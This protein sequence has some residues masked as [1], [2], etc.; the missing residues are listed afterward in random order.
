MSRPHWDRLALALSLAAV[1]A[2]GLVTWGIFDG[3][4]HLEDEF[5]NLW[6]A[7]VMADGRLRLPS[8]PEAPSFLVPFVVD[9]EG[10]RFGKYPPGWPAA[11]S[12]GARAGAAWLVNPLLA[13][14][15]VWLTYRLASRFLSGGASLLAAGL[16]ASSPIFLIQ[17]GAIMSHNLSLALALIFCLAWLD[18]FVPPLSAVPEWVLA[19]VAG[20]SLGLLAL[21]RP[22]TAVGVGL[23]FAGHAVGQLRSQ[24]GRRWLLVIGGLAAGLTALIPWWQFA[25][26][27]D[28]WLNL[29]RLWWHYDRVGFGPGVGLVQGGHSLSTAW[30]NAGYSLE[31]GMHDAFGWPYLSWLFLPFGLWA[32]RR[33]SGA[34]LPLSI[35]P[36]LVL[37]YAAYWI[38]AGLLG[39]RYYYEGLPG[40]AL[41]TAAGVCWLADKALP[42][43]RRW[44]RLAVTGLLAG[45]MTV[46]MV[47]YLPARLTSL[48]GL[49]G[50]DR[51]ELEPL[52]NVDLDRTL[53]FVEP[54][55]WTGYANLL[56]LAPPFA[57]SRTFVAW[58][59]G[60][61]ADQRVKLLFEGH[62][63]YRYDPATPGVLYLQAEG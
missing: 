44:T 53:I 43:Q 32:L 27:G 2:G 42:G 9:Y 7:E 33:C 6:Q 20:A 13:G 8:P 39:P 50:I 11:L 1:V 16:V 35:L 56:P 15:A 62:R 5:A 59:R 23:P 54:G 21:T 48:H 34:W 18:L 40:L 45:L 63:V 55:H 57:D 41:A 31:V 22:L 49:Y 12:L 25:L 47:L 58:S 4:P 61:A 17:S 19:C 29:Y 24:R 38:G 46:N 51:A 28:P 10:W 60:P 36:A 26:S 30:H 3:L 37:A 14:L 52:L